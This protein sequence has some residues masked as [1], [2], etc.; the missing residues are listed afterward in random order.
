[1]RTIDEVRRRRAVEE[2]ALAISIERLPVRTTETRLLELMNEDIETTPERIAAV[3]LAVDELIV[4][5]LLV[6][7][8]SVLKPTPGA[9]R[10]AEL[11]LGL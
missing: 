7:D 6:R 9:S 4:V 8:G 2:A 5:G 3:E 11:E 1:M 10:S